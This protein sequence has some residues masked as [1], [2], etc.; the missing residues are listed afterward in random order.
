M[1]SRSRRKDARLGAEGEQQALQ[2]ATAARSRVRALLDALPAEVT[3]EVMDVLHEGYARALTLEGAC[4]QRAR[5]LAEIKVEASDPEA[6]KLLA[7]RLRIMRN[8]LRKLRS[9]LK[10]LRAW[11]EEEG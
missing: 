2:A 11:A 9:A 6:A 8:E 10:T 7:D 3:D 1:D 5:E 4:R